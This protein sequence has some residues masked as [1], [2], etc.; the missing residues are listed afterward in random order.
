MTRTL[1][2]IAREMVA[3]YDWLAARCSW[4]F[5]P[6]AD[7]TGTEIELATHAIALGDAAEEIRTLLAPAPS[8][9]RAPHTDACIG[10]VHDSLGCS[11]GVERIPYPAPEP[12]R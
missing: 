7:E 1:E 5:A 11:C 9:T 3:A 4:Q 2:E 8:T 6:C 12:K 10:R